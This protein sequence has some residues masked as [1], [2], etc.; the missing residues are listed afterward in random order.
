[1]RESLNELAARH[2][3]FRTS[4]AMQEDQLMQRITDRV[5]MPLEVTDSTEEEAKTQVKA[6]VRPFDL[7]EAPLLRAGLICLEERRHVL[8]LDMHHIVS[9]GVSMD[10]FVDEFARL[11]AGEHLAP[12]TIHYKDYA[13][14]LREKMQDESYRVQEHYWLQAFKEEVPVLQLPTDYARPVVRQFEGDHAGQVWS[15]HETDRL[16]QLCAKQGVTLY[17]AL[18]AAYGVLLSRYAG[19]EDIVVGSPVAGR[20]HPDAERM[21]GMFVGTLAM[22]SRPAGSKRFDAYLA[23]V[24]AAVLGGRWRI[25]TTRSRSWWRRWRYGGIRAATRCLTRCWCCRTCR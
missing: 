9:D 6:F 4:F 20:R 2:E 16:K 22:R 1:M 18:L 3:S 12:L 19:Q 10:V 5:N 7:G 17:M 8:L 15:E 13:V 21:I 23:E 14:W 25:R 11:Y 24:K